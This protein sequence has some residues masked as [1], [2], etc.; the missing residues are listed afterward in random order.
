MYPAAGRYPAER[1]QPGALS[2]QRQVPPHIPR[3][4]YAVS[5]SAP[6][7]L[8][9]SK[10][11]E[12]HDGQGQAAMRAAS[13][14]ATR[15]LQLAG[16]LV[17]PG[18]TTDQL[19]AAVHDFLTANGAYPS[20]LSYHGFPKSIC[21]SVNEVV[22]HGIPDNRPLREGDV[23]NIDVTAYLNGHHGDT[24]ATFFVGQ[25]SA[26]AV[27]LVAV[28]QQA[29]DAAIQLC[30]PDVPFRAIGH[31]IHSIADAA[32]MSVIREFVGH[33]IGKV[34]HAAPA[35]LHHR[36]WR[37]GSMALGQ[38]FTIEPILTLGGRKH[39]T[40]A[41]GWTVVT[42]DGSLT[43]QFEHTLLVTQQGVEVL[44]VPPGGQGAGC[45]EAQQQPAAASG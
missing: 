25:P 20:P 2:P 43:A 22:C 10:Q 26:A 27:E 39:R 18:V 28:T 21:T 30:G 24:N 4:A 32:G 23:V 35:V 40:W 8:G 7:Q 13:Q 34:F 16:G 38:S 36:N 17:Q 37:P 6:G 3:P 1:L 14:L 33:G 42:A 11:P 12:V 41:D 45:P 5:G 9:L 29:L 31:A 44:T 15:A 19:D